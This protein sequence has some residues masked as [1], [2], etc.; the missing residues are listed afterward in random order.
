MPYAGPMG[1]ICKSSVFPLYLA[2][3]ASNPCVSGRSGLV[4]MRGGEK[5]I[6]TC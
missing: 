5:E 4:D 3:F 2:D 1:E 6:D